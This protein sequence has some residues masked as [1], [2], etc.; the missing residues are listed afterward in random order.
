MSKLEVVVQ[1]ALV[2]P[3]RCVVVAGAV[4]YAALSVV[5]AAAQ[6]KEPINVTAT[7]TNPDPKTLPT[8]SVWQ[9]DKFSPGKVLTMVR[10]TFPNVPDFTCESWCYESAL[11]FLD[12][13]ALEAG[14]LELRHRLN[15]AAQV[16]L[17]TTV[18]PEAEAIEF[19]ARM[20]LEKEGVGALPAN[21]P[22]V[23]LCWQLRRAPGFASAADPYP[24]FIKRCFLFTEKG[25]TFL[26]KTTRRKIPCRPAEDQYNNPPWVQ[27]YVG[28]WQQIP[29]AGP[30]SWADYS[31]N[32]YTTPV[33]GAVSR[34]GKYVA[35]IANGSASMMAQA[36]HDCM[37][38]N[39]PWLPADALPAAR[40]WRV[41][42]YVM[43]NDPESLLA[44]VVKDF[45]GA[46]P[47]TQ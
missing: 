3:W 42:V 11:T 45:P 14:K 36:W 32:R 5:V 4:S 40:R 18:T 31:P 12:A 22:F 37:H 30:T 10:A 17:V 24:E 47:R 13:R 21:P 1:R 34:D 29:E 43:K 41:K 23:N 8:L 16:L 27:M 6:G 35:A 19:V 15:D 20:E 38:N 33:I 46:K 7:A 9:D 39:P 25:L 28:T 2:R 26:D 44:R